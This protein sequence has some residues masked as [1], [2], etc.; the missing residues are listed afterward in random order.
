[1]WEW[2]RKWREKKKIEGRGRGEKEQ[3]AQLSAENKQNFFDIIH[4][5]M[6][7][8]L[9]FM[10]LFIRQTFTYGSANDL[11][12][13]WLYHLCLNSHNLVFPDETGY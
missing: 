6:R 13:P 4:D 10:H 5:F 12:F 11:K 8:C 3:I 9:F 1:M 7:W 2:V